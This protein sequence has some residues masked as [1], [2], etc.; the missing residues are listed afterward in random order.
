MPNGDLVHLWD[1]DFVDPG[2]GE[3][4]TARWALRWAHDFPLRFL[5]RVDRLMDNFLDEDRDLNYFLYFTD[6][7]NLN[8]PLHLPRFHQ[9]DKLMVNFVDFTWKQRLRFR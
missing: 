4:L 5:H 1:F 8:N 2:F 6:L 7:N 9:G 3:L